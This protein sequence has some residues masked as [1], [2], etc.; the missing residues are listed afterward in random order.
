MLFYEV[1]ET[2]EGLAV[3]ETPPGAGRGGE[4][5]GRRFD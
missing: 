5:A 3:A 4:R 1:I 2:D